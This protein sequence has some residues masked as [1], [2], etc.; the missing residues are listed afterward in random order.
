[1]EKIK[2]RKSKVAKIG[3]LFIGGNYPISVQ[4]MTNCNVM[5]T[6]ATLNQIYQLEEAGCQLIRIAFP[7]LES[8]QMIPLIKKNTKIPIMADIHFNHQLAIEAIRMGADGIRIN[9]GNIKKKEYFQE[10]IKQA[11]KKQVMIRFGINAGSINKQIL[12]KYGKPDDKALYEET[13]KL[14][15]FLETIPYKNIVLSIKSSDVLD[16]IKANLLIAKNCDYPLHIGITEA[17]YDQA[18]ITKSAVGM[19]ILLYHGIGD[20]IRVSLSGD[21]VRE[22]YV[23]Y[24]ILRSLGLVNYGINIIACPT[25]GRCMVDIE[26]IGRTIEERLKDIQTPLTIAIM[27]C[28]V[29]G[30]GEAK[31]ADIGIAF[32]Q[33]EGILYLKGKRIGRYKKDK[34]IEQLYLEV[35]RIKEENE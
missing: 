30:P 3:D 17:G 25:C 29:N 2:R 35:K 11:Q 7:D 34:A 18:G 9:P 1:M 23:G 4:S 24:D 15:K 13:M 32:S 6:E 22:I 31:N 5:D 16:T 12:K 14:I 27:G 26:N 33:E 10:I 28:I 19:G 21:P 8:C 20:T